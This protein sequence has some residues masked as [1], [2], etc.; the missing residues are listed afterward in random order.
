MYIKK[1][2][3][4]GAGVHI[5]TVVKFLT[6]T[7]VSKIIFF[8][9]FRKYFN[10]LLMFIFCF[11]FLPF[12]LLIS[13]KIAY[14]IYCVNSIFH[15]CSSPVISAKIAYNIYCVNSIFHTC[16]HHIFLSKTLNFI[17]NIRKCI[18]VLFLVKMTSFFSIFSAMFQNFSV[19]WTV[20]L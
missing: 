10:Y 2:V 15:T 1:T 5:Q 20:Y 6:S 13:A 16:S 11:K 17:S 14:N 18:Y 19:Q 4:Q 3:T 9:H 8:F 7:N 12:I